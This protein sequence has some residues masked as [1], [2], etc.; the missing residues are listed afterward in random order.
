MYETDNTQIEIEDTP[1]AEETKHT[2]SLTLPSSK[3]KKVITSSIIAVVVIALIVSFSIFHKS[4]F[5]KVKD[6]AVEIAGFAY[7]GDDYFTLDTNQ[8]DENY[9]D[10]E[11]W[12]QLLFRDQ[13]DQALEAIKMVNDRLGFNGSLYTKMI[14]TTALMGRQTDET[15]KYRVSWTYHPDDGLEVTYEVK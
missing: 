3:K 5:E 10:L 14:E 7:T 9:N 15:S 4:E 12:Q 11:Y 8:F 2:D 6:E 1:S 13:Q